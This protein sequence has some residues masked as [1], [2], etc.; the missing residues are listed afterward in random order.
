[1]APTREAGPDEDSHDSRGAQSRAALGSALFTILVP[2]TVVG[3]VP[4]LILSGRREPIS[5]PVPLQ[6]LGAIFAVAGSV[7]YLVCLTGFVRLG[8]GTPSPADPPRRLVV[9]GPYRFARNPMYL[10]VLSMV[11]GE[12]LIFGSLRLGIYAAALAAAFHV[13]VVIYEEPVL[14]RMFGPA[15]EAYRTSVPRWLGR[16]RR[17]R[18]PHGD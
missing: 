5:A 9:V 15:Y 12:A 14:A 18:G 2:G 3:M 8:R 7:L 16:R 13:F 17:L 11:L 6:I 1:M 10:A 4:F